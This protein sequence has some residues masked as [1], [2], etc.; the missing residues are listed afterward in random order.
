[1]VETVL[2]F[3][4]ADRALLVVSE[5]PRPFVRTGKMVT[6]NRAILENLI[7][8]ERSVEVSITEF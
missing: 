4:Y 6:T 3:P 2:L 5:R 7:L 1:M 8:V